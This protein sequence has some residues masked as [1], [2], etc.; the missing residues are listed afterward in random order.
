MRKDRENEEG[1][2]G[3]RVEVKRK[4]GNNDGETRSGSS[5]A[6]ATINQTN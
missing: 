4:D 5:A 1:E 2:K 3:R 6:V